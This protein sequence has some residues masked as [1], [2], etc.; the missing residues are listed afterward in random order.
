MNAAKKLAREDLRGWLNQSI[1]A[2]VTRQGTAKV[3]MEIYGEFKTGPKRK[4]QIWLTPIVAR[5]LGWKWGKHGLS[6]SVA[7]SSDYQSAV[8]QVA[9]ALTLL[10]GFS[11]S[12]KQMEQQ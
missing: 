10:Y 5:A 12:I 1:S 8:N 6:V 9:S 7:N 11:V 2:R 3:Y 4:G